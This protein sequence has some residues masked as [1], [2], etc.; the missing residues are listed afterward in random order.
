MKEKEKKQQRSAKQKQKL[1]W[2][3]GHHGH[4]SAMLRLYEM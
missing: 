2:H 3:V 4:N 1:S